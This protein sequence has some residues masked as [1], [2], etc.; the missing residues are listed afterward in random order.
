MNNI[1]RVEDVKVRSDKNGQDRNQYIRET[2][3]VGR[4]GL[5]NT[6]SKTEVV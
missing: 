6:R 4:F 5:E 3:H 1:S 2:E